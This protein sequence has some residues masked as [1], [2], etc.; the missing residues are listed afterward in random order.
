MERSQAGPNAAPITAFVDI[1]PRKIGRERRGKPV[2]RFLDARRSLPDAFYLAAVGVEGARDLIRSN[3]GS[4]SLSE[5][6]DFL[7]LH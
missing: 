2:L 4:E 6:R 1:N 5:G 3:L 7:C